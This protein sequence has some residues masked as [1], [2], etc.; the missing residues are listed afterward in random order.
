LPFGACKCIF[1]L[2]FIIAVAIVVV[3]A[4]NGG[5]V[6]VVGI[7][8]K[9]VHRDIKPANIILDANFHAKVM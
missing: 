7:S 8:L 4:R 9:V 2:V 1:I 3:V 5:D 6:V